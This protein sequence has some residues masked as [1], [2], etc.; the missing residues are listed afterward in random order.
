[1]NEQEKQQQKLIKR[2]YIY[3][4]VGFVFFTFIF[5]AALIQNISLFT[6]IGLIGAIACVASGWVMYRKL[7]HL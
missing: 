1:M 5:I 3:F 6:I 2:T 7:K 4:I